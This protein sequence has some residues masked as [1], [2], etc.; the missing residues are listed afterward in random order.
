MVGIAHPHQGD[1]AQPNPRRKLNRQHVASSLKT[2]FHR[3]RGCHSF[4]GVNACPSTVQ[5]DP[6]VRRFKISP[7][8]MVIRGFLRTVLIIAE[9]LQWIA[10][11]QH[12]GLLF[13]NLDDMRRTWDCWH[14]PAPMGLDKDRC[15]CSSTHPRARLPVLLG[16][17]DLGHLAGVVGV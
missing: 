9:R 16:H 7:R 13:P 14:H 11:T 6:Y 4:S 17:R 5:G 3:G 2:A 1:T 8:S 12:P 15:R 10:I